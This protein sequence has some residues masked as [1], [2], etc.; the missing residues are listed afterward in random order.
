MIRT[1]LAGACP[2][3]SGWYAPA[4]CG[5]PDRGFRLTSVSREADAAVRLPPWNQRAKRLR[6]VVGP[7]E[8]VQGCRAPENGQPQDHRARLA[9][10][11]RGDKGQREEEVDCHALR[12]AHV[13]PHPAEV[14]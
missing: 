2:T 8:D 13:E 12:V 9:W 11:R 5:I 10:Y 4:R 7:E 14:H 6:R 1:A 3:R